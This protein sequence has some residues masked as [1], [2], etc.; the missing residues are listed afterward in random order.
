MEVPDAH[1]AF[2][3]ILIVAAACFCLEVLDEVDGFGDL[4]RY[5]SLIGGISLAFGCRGGGYDGAGEGAGFGAVDADVYAV[6]LWFDDDFLR[7]FGLIGGQFERSFNLNSNVG[8]DV[9]DPYE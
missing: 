4:G 2:Y 8:G 5:F 3:S 9:L 1:C 6:F 7:P